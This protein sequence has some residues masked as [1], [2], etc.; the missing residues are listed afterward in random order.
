[1]VLTPM[2]ESQRGQ[3]DSID[4]EGCQEYI[5]R[6]GADPASYEMFVVLET[7]Q[8]ES[9]GSITRTGFVEGWARVASD[10]GGGIGPDWDSQRR[11]I[12]S[13]ISAVTSDPAYFKTIYDFA[14]KVGREPGQKA[15]D[16][17]FALAFWSVL[18]APTMNSWRSANV[19]WLSAWSR[20][21][22]EKYGNV[23]SAGGDDEEEEVVEYKRT[24]SRDLWSQTRLFAAKTLQDESLSFW[25]EDGAW[26]GMIDE[27]VVWAREKGVVPQGGERMEE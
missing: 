8:A 18:F 25:S 2:P 16:M 14:F 12:R 23:K 22:K 27:F 4:A 26:P 10:S 21:L 20:F 19:D 24:V 17:G 15:L 1:M 11:Y 5:Q 9:I 6:L 3:A 7:V 13:R